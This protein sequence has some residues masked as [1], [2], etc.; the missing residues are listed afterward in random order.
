MSEFF[1][2]SIFFCIF[3]ALKFLKY[4]DMNEEERA[5]SIQLMEEYR[6]KLT[7]NSDLCKEFLVKAG[8]YTEH[9]VLAAPYKHLYVPPTQ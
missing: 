3:A 5:I 4:F 1:F 7:G 8:I 9:G 2:V 6:K